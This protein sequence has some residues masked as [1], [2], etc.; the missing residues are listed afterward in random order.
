VVRRPRV[1]RDLIILDAR[2][3]RGGPAVYARD[4]A[5]G[6]HALDEPALE[7]RVVRVGAAFRPWGRAAVAAMAKR[8]G[9]DLV[10]GLH[11]ETPPIA[12]PTVVT[13]QDVVPLDYPGSV[14]NPVRR[15]AYRR[16][17]TS[18]LRRATRVI[19]PSR[20]TRER[21]VAHGA[22]RERVTVVPLGVGPR[23]HPLDDGEREQA[24]R[25][26]GGG[27]RYVVA[28]S[29]RRAHKNLAG[30]Q[31]AVA[32][33]RG[34]VGVVLVGEGVSSHGRLTDGELARLYGGADA[35]VLPAL[36]EGFGLPALE[37]LACGVPVVCGPRTGALEVLRPGAVEVDVSRPG[38]LA[39]GI[40]ALVDDDSLRMRLGDAGRAVAVTLTCEAMGRA[41]LGVY[42]DVLANTPR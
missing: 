30:L 2:V 33:L 21:L 28:S 7:V 35:M 40:Q 13:I 3:R 19:V 16:L 39:A 42:R 34:D 4:L 36:F 6:L 27:R 26:F 10:H 11:L 25:D 1:D 8:W 22:A 41:T 14:P 31:R 24:R 9:A 23:F 15:F 18:S 17:L 20:L 38:D 37:A 29:G 5:D 32:L 12:G